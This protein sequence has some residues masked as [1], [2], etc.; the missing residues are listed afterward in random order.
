MHRKLWH[1]MKERGLDRS[2]IEI[3]K[4]DVVA[5]VNCLNML[6]EQQLAYIINRLSL[7]MVRGTSGHKLKKETLRSSHSC[8]L[9]VVAGY[10]SSI[11]REH[12]TKNNNFVMWLSENF[13]P[14]HISIPYNRKIDKQLRRSLDEYFQTFLT[15]GLMLNLD[16]R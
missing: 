2:L 4:G 13:A 8:S 14:M 12:S 7:S 16:E 5:M 1:K 3:K 9:Q 6:K 11:Y 10:C 15:F